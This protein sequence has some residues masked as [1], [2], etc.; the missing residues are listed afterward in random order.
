MWFAVNVKEGMEVQALGLLRQTAES[1][2]VED[3]FVPMVR[4]QT[5]P[6]TQPAAQHASQH[7]PQPAVQSEMQPAMQ[8]ATQRTAQSAAQPATR[9]LIPGC[10]VAVCPSRKEVRTALR[11]ARGIEDMLADGKSA[12]A[13]SDE[14]IAL[15]RTLVTPENHEVAFSEG[16]IERGRVVVK[17]GP[18]LG[19][20]D[21]IRRVNH[22][23]RRAYL[24]ARVAGR[25]VDAQVGLRVV[26]APM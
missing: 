8:P 16:V 2:G 20:E 26:K 18:L 21:I 23:K 15:I 19:H 4:L 3:L 25:Q 11:R 17:S 14:E 5:Q 10:V 6:E 1:A 12:T 7:A 9:P 13:L 22:R 24:D